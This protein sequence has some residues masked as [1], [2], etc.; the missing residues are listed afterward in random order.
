MAVQAGRAPLSSTSAAAPADV[1]VP[2]LVGRSPI[3]T[4]TG[5]AGHLGWLEREAALD[6]TPLTVAGDPLAA[7]LRDSLLRAAAP[8]GLL[9]EGDAFSALWAHRHVEPTRA[10][11]LTWVDGFQAIVARADAGIHEPSQLAGRRI[12]LPRDDDALVDARRA[13]ARRGLRAALGL[14]GLFPDEVAERDIDVRGASEPY[15]A[16]LAALERGEVDAIHLAGAG[17]LAAA[18]RIGAATV[19]DLGASLDPAVRASASTPAAIT[20]DARLLERRPTLVVRLLAVMLRAGAWAAEQPQNAAPLIAADLGVTTEQLAGAHGH[21]LGEQL[22]V[23]LSERKLAALRTQHEFLRTYGFLDED[24]DLG[25]W[26]D[27]RPL[28]EARDLL[29]AERTIW[30]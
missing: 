20:V 26:V 8:R 7:P 5:V 1:D 18:S 6:G 24:V 17:G 21:G 29:A 30:A 19:V 10:I 12:G 15:A 16:E 25:A 11:G 22:Q 27:P 3:P 9:R 2:V 28:A 4:A 13:A 23:D 14:A